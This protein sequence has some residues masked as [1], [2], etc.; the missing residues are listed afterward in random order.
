MAQNTERHQFHI[1]TASPEDKTRV[2][3]VL[4]TAASKFWLVDTTVT[5]RV[6]LTIKCYSEKLGNGFGL[7][8]R[9]VDNLIV[10]DFNAVGGNTNSFSTTMKFIISELNLLFGHRLQ[11]AT[12]ENYIKAESTLPES[13]EAREFHRKIFTSPIP[14]PADKP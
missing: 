6:P 8:A 7:G 3:Q 2:E 4:V 13:Q 1:E 5:S 14:R 9:I 12:K 10:L 11:P